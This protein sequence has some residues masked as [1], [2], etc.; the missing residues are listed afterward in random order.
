MA[1]LSKKMPSQVLSQPRSQPAPL[2]CAR[3]WQTRENWCHSAN[4]LP[5]CGSDIEGAEAQDTRA[6]GRADVNAGVYDRHVFVHGFET[7]RCRLGL[8]ALYW[9]QSL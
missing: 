4:V 6:R 9:Q 5:G 8:S 3:P 1:A 2:R 7:A